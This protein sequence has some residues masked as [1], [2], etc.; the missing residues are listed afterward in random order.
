MLERFIVNAP[1]AQSNAQCEVGDRTWRELT[2]ARGKWAA[3]DWVRAERRQV[4]HV[5]SGF[6]LGSTSNVKNA[7]N[8]VSLARG[9]VIEYM[10]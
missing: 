5:R 3:L 6:G 2:E 10:S 7:S 9:R 8:H 1:V 4:Q